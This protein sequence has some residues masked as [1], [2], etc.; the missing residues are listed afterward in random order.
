MSADVLVAPRK[1]ASDLI[2]RMAILRLVDND[3]LLL[4]E[5]IAIFMDDSPRLLADIH[6]ALCHGD[7]KKL[8]ISAHT[9]KG[10]ASTFSSS[11]TY[12]AANVLEEMGRH[13]GIIGGAAA[14][15]HLETTLLGLQNALRAFSRELQ[16]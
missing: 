10:S 16:S 15:S 2:D 13:G 9:L 1:A 7:A 11:A 3:V 14:A 8:Q 5:L 12:A 4:L 6:A